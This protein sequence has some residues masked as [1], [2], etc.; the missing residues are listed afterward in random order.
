MKL[1]GR[2][3]TPMTNAPDHTRRADDGMYEGFRNLQMLSKRKD[4]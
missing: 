2:K 4:E 1:Y 3:G